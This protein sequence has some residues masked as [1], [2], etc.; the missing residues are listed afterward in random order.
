MTL[1]HTSSASK[2]S[3][4]VFDERFKKLVNEIHAA[5]TPNEIMVGLRNKILNIYNVEM[6]TIFLIDA[7]KNILVSWVLLGTNSLRKIRMD[8]NRSSITGFVA[9]TRQILNISNAYDKEELQ[10]I[11]STLVFDSSWDEKGGTRTRQILA[12][13]I[14]HKSNLMGVIEL[15][16]KKQGAEFDTIDE[17]RVGEL[18]DTLAIA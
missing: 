5:S 7:R 16:N 1:K 18:A 9:D 10:K 17:K 6:A 8:V 2:N 15:I 4:Q 3:Q 14:V 11:H 13:P 12:A